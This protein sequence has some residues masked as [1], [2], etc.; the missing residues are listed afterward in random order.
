MPHLANSQPVAGAA[1][2]LETAA[3]NA[4]AAAANGLMAGPPVPRTTPPTYPS[5]GSLSTVRPWIPTTACARARGAL[6]GR[7][8]AYC[9][10]S[11]IAVYTNPPP[12]VTEEG[13]PLLE[14][15]EPYPD[16]P[17]R[18]SY[19]PMKAVCE[20]ELLSAFGARRP[21]HGWHDDIPGEATWRPSLATG[22]NRRDPRRVDRCIQRRRSSSGG[23]ETDRQGEQQDGSSR[24]HSAA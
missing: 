5:T 6:N 23:G 14:W 21:R 20:R 13:A 9:F 3:T 4:P 24:S 19:G 8:G 1:A 17:S 11:T 16:Q 22:D 7:G 2:A 12:Q 15:N 18:P 10:V